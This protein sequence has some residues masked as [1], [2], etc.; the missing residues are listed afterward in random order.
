MEAV[1]RGEQVQWQ[2]G[3]NT[4]RGS[5]FNN[6][7]VAAGASGS[8]QLC[9]FPRQ[10]PP[11]H[12]HTHINTHHPTLCPTAVISRPACH[13]AAPHQSPTSCRSCMT[14]RSGATSSEAKCLCGRLLPSAPGVRLARRSAACFGKLPHIFCC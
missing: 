5:H 2:A 7:T 12:A 3:D 9:S 1:G 13:A 4:A 6:H 8:D 10:P 11:P 14:W